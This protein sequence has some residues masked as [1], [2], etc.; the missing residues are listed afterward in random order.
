MSG[1]YDALAAI[2]RAE[3]ENGAFHDPETPYRG[4]AWLWSADRF[5]SHRPDI[6][7][8][9]RAEFY[10]LPGN[11]DVLMRVGTVQIGNRG[12]RVNEDE[13]APLEEA[14]TARR[15]LGDK[16][17]AGAYAVVADTLAIKPWY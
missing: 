1:E 16:A 9:E 11:S 10:V 4:I 6:N 14:E 17:V 7:T 15:Y 5:S 12:Y 2:I 3:R 13:L 8:S